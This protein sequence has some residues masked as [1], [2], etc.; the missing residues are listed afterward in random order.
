MKSINK[1]DKK[2]VKKV[3]KKAWCMNMSTNNNKE[4]WIM[5]GTIG[6]QKYFPIKM[7]DPIGKFIAKGNSKSE[8]W[9]NAAIEIK[10]RTK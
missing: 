6:D 10:N 7:A 8:A 3:F 9:K 5:D 4:Y 2:A 1:E